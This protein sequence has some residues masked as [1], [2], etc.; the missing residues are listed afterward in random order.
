MRRPIKIALMTAAVLA[1][2]L[3]QAAEN[4]FLA[5]AEATSDSS[6]YFYIGTALPLPGSNLGKG[7]VLHLWA[8]YQTYSYDAGATEIDVSVDSLSAAFGYHDSGSNYWWNARLGVVQS[9]VG[10]EPNDPGNDSAGVNTNLKVQLEG[11]T[12]SSADFK[13]N[14]G[15][16]YIF[17]R[18][19]Y[20]MRVRALMRNNNNSYH[21]PELIY[22]GDPEYSAMQ[23]G[24]VLNEI[25]VNENWSLGLKAGFRFDDNN[26]SEYAGIE[27]TIPY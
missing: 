1:S 16:E 7:V 4:L 25:A 27:L 19:A 20:W 17:G 6:R 24:W 22:Q 15:I 3:S 2:S 11:E 23:L 18:S 12:R 13:L 14:G 9:D 5:G 8:D 10:L 21:G 26:T